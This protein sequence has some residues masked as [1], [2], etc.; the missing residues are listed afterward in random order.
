VFARRSKLLPDPEPFEGHVVELLATELRQAIAFAR[1][2]DRLGRSAAARELWTS[3]YEELSQAHPG[4]V[5][6]MLARAEAHVLRLSL[7]YALLDRSAIV[8]PVHLQAAVELWGYAERSVRFLFGEA[9]GDPLADHILRALERQPEMTRTEIRDL[10][11][12]HASETQVD[13]ALALLL[14][15]RLAHVEQRPTGGRPAEVWR[16]A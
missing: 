14:E 6:A 7:L 10:L 4:L 5:G 1:V 15:L 2:Q 3:I 8:E 16:R 11:A 9:T 13:A 12:R